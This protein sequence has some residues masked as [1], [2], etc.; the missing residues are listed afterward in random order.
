MSVFCVLFWCFEESMLTEGYLFYISINIEKR[1][2]Q[3]IAIGVRRE[4]LLAQECQDHMG[5]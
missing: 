5:H 4:L 2:N 1:G 3:S